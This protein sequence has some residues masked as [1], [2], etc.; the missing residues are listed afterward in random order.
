MNSRKLVSLARG[1]QRVESPTEI[2]IA[3][4]RGLEFRGTDSGKAAAI[5][6][7]VFDIVDSREGQSWKQR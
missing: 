3:V 5:A 2:A 4:Q 6:A 1:K 7:D